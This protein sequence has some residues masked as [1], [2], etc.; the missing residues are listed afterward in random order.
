MP[1][2]MIC[3]CCWQQMHVPIPLRGVWSWPFKMFGIR[4]SRMNPST[5]TICEL[6]FTRIMR[7]RSIPVEVSILFADLRGYT[8]MS[9]SLSHE[10]VSAMLDVFYDECSAAIWKCDGLLNKTIGDSVMAIFNFPIRIGDHARHAVL[11]AQVI[12]DRC[13]ARR[14]DLRARHPELKATDFGVG[15]GIDCGHARFGEF[16]RAHRDLTAIG[17]VVNTAARAQSAAR[18]GEILVTQSVSS[19]AGV[20]GAGRDYDLKGIDAPVRLYAI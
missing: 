4:P 9:R 11:A 17:P 5:C 20:A 10:T 18:A 14:E 8:G 19:Q 2:A 3:K 7:A 12:R 15:I 16:G 6:M 13:N 1:Q